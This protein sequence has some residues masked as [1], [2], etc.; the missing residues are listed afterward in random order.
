MST[1]HTDRA[2]GTKSVFKPPEFVQEPTAE[3]LSA[4]AAY[5]PLFSDLDS[6]RSAGS[7]SDLP[8]TSAVLGPQRYTPPPVWGLEK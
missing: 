3:G 5:A 2:D 6:P 8:L 1:F 4:L 7:S